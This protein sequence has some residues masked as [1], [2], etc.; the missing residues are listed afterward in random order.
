MELS[1]CN[2]VVT[3]GAV[4]IGRE[5][6]LGLAQAGMNVCLHFRRSREAAQA[7]AAEI[8]GAGVNAVTVHAD[9][10]DPARSAEQIISAARAA[11]GPVDVLINNASLFE[12]GTL[13]DTTIDDWN[14]HVT[15]NLAAPLCLCR[16]FAAQLE[17]PRTGAIINIADWRALRPVPGHLAYTVSKAGLV[18]LTKVLAQELAPRIRVNAVAPG[19]V[20]PP[21]GASPDDLDALKEAVPL[22]QTGQPADVVRTV[23]FLLQSDFITGEVIHVTGGQ[24]L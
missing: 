6:A 8:E 13:A 4:R 2:A 19:A 20:L 3:G 7:T 11:F 16:Q 14:Q 24:Q 21:P 15:V 10:N 5:T 22:Q 17:P 23:L 1:G 18:C 12:P 9:L